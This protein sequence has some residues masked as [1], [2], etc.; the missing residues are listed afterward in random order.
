MN[1][2]GGETI[3]GNWLRFNSVE[4]WY[5]ARINYS[6]RYSRAL[7]DELARSIENILKSGFRIVSDKYGIEDQNS[8]YILQYLYH[9]ARCRHHFGKYT[10]GSYFLNTITLSPALD[11]IIH[12]LQFDT[13]EYPDYKLLMALIFTRYEPDL[14]KFKFDSKRFIAPETI[15]YAQK[16]NERF[17][18]RLVSNKDNWVGYFVYNRTIYKR[19]KY[20]PKAETI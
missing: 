20:S 5:Q 1:G 17:P 8:L 3:R 13:P 6:K 15:E 19:K 18:R 10:L 4:K 2:Y 12:T 11:P 9:E 16:I 7:S 14:L